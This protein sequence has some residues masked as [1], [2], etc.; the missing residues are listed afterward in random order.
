LQIALACFGIEQAEVKIF[1]SGLINRTWKVW[2]PSAKYILQKVNDRVFSRP[3]DIGANIRMIG[4]FLRENNPDYYF[5]SHLVS[6][7]GEDVVHVEGEGWFR[8]MPFVDKS[9]SYDVVETSEQAY[10]AAMQFGRFTKSLSKF[11]AR[12]LCITIPNFHNLH[13]RYQQFLESILTGNKGRVG[14]SKKIIEEL[15]SHKGI[16]DEFQAIVVSKD[17][18]LRVTHHDTKI[19]NVLFDEAGKSLCVIDLDTVMPG[20]FIS[21][22]GD[23]MRTY[24]SPV[25]EEEKDLRKV[26][27]RNEFYK[28]IVAG[29][30]DEMRDELTQT[31]N[32]YF[33]FAGKFMVY[34]QALRF[35]SDHL[36]DD[37]YYG[38]QYEGHN[39]MRA[40]NQLALLQEL[41]D[42]P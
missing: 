24:L 2:T 36:K 37:V 27:V 1:G 19:S 16:V 29:Y 25:S 5:I 22:V 35:M 4:Q 12:K 26:M 6:K 9:F 40:N 32:K 8:L 17:F 7:R 14:E 15:L 18:K 38:S 42:L 3:T 11:N 20:Y 28:A 33:R 31:E 41:E 13:L 39:L 34:M 10:E 23:M 30:N 21:D